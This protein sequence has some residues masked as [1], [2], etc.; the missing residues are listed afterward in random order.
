MQGEDLLGT[1]PGGN[2]LEQLL[3]P[4]ALPLH[5]PSPGERVP[6]PGTAAVTPLHLP[7]TPGPTEEIT[8]KPSPGFYVPHE[9]ARHRRCFLSV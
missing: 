5:H 6:F 2:R 9:R 1:P 4:A 7:A 3:A 8:Q